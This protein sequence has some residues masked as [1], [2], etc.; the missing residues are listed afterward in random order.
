L[1]QLLVPTRGV[2]FH[3]EGDNELPEAVQSLHRIV[4]DIDATDEMHAVAIHE[5]L[6]SVR[7]ILDY[8]RRKMREA[9]IETL[10]SAA[11]PITARAPATLPELGANPSPSPTTTTLAGGID[12]GEGAAKKLPPAGGSGKHVKPSERRAYF[13]LLY[14]EFKCER[15]LTTREAWDY[16]RE[17]GIGASGD[18][19]E[20]RDYSPPANFSTFEQQVSKGRNGVDESK[21]SSRSGRRCGKSIVRRDEFA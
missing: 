2:S 15:T 21:H 4:D 9:G 5:R 12:K 13:A 1:R 8:A 20:L 16:L 7:G 18:V 11:T 19:G 10:P 14:A 6:L 3:N 17:F